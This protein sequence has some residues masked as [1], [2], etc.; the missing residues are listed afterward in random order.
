ML[1]LAKSALSLS[2]SGRRGR[3]GGRPGD[4]S[5]RSRG[6]P[7]GTKYYICNREGH[8][9]PEC[10]TNKSSSKG[11]KGETH[12]SG[13]SA[14]LAVDHLQS[15]GECEVGK[16]LI[17][18][19]DSFPTTGILLDCGAIAHMFTNKQHFSMYVNSINEF[20]TVGGHNHIPVAGQGSV[21]FSTIL[22]NGHLNITLHEVLHIPYLGA[23]LI[24][25]GTL[26]YQG[27]SVKSLDDG[28]VLSQDGKELFRASLTGPTRT[29]YYVQYAPLRSGTAYLTSSPLSMHL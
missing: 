7:T 20:V 12:Q 13:G 23:N 19:S 1:L 15:L 8:W 26:H 29:L 4:R 16:M 9:A 17:A 25:L 21:R 5:R 28:L 18:T 14:N 11:N 24:S 6:H 22:P 3:R 10:P 2:Y 27:V